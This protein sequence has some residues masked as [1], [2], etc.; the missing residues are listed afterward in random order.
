MSPV[1]VPNVTAWTAFSPNFTANTPTSVELF[2]RQCG[3]DTIQIRGKWT[4]SAGTASECRMDL[5]TGYT[6][7]D[8][9]KIPT[10]AIAGGWRYNTTAGGE[11]GTVQM[12]PSKTYVTFGRQGTGSGGL[13]KLNGN[14][15]A[16]ASLSV[17]M[18]TITVPIA[19]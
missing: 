1:Y 2:W 12:E 15:A 19:V 5:P 9:G 8:T 7:A 6:T 14:N 16:L 11:I 3:P 4:F 13:Q 18:E 10:I 17:S